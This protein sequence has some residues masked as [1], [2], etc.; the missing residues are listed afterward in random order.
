MI[1]NNSKWEK[2]CYKRKL[3]KHRIILNINNIKQLLKLQLLKRMYP[4]SM[5]LKKNLDDG[6]KQRR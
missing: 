5:P 1:P 2:L 3:Y 6:S 4:A